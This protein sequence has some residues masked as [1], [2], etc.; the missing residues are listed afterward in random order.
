MMMRMGILDFPDQVYF[1]CVTRYGNIVMEPVKVQPKLECK[2]AAQEK[3]SFLTIERAFTGR[4]YSG[5]EYSNAF[6]A[7][8]DFNWNS[9]TFVLDEKQFLQKIT[10]VAQI[11][12]AL[13]SGYEE[14]EKITVGGIRFSMDVRADSIMFTNLNDPHKASFKVEK[15][16]PE[17]IKYMK[18]SIRATAESPLKFSK[19][20]PPQIVDLH[21]KF[22]LGTSIDD[23]PIS[24]D[25]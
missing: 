15:S 4:G 16:M 1:I 8:E 11:F 9:T 21:N 10:G 20:Q 24:L 6:D 12:D 18:E 2:L 13:L 7:V 23:N 14:Q 5:T 19:L 3:L 17:F 25:S 22:N